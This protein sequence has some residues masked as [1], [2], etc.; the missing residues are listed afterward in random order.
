MRAIVRRNRIDISGVNSLPPSSWEAM[1]NELR[2]EYIPGQ[3]PFG[4]R[5]LVLANGVF[6]FRIN[7]LFDMADNDI[8]RILEKYGIA[9]TVERYL[10]H[11]ATS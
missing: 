8:V 11:G 1:L 6:I 10:A 3:T 7:T 4:K 2:S 5:M 9:A